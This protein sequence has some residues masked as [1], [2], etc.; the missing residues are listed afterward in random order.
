MRSLPG[1]ESGGRCGGNERV[2][3]GL[4]IIFLL[5]VNNNDLIQIITDLLVLLVSLVQFLQGCFK[6]VFVASLIDQVYIGNLILILAESISS[7][8]V[9]R[10]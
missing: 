9:T 10:A 6:Q 1:A 5:L 4:I 2:N 8:M 7:Y 3:L